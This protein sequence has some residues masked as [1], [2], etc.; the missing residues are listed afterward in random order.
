[1]VCEPR[2][3]VMGVQ[4][5]RLLLFKIQC[6]ASLCALFNCIVK[7][8]HLPW[9][10]IVFKENGVMQRASQTLISQHHACK[11]PHFGK[12]RLSWRNHMVVYEV[13]RA[14]AAR[15]KWQVVLISDMEYIITTY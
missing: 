2:L 13:P 6:A 9:R 1:M 7:H 15:S 14:L 3:T 11:M 10:T 4:A 8:F 5:P 12:Y